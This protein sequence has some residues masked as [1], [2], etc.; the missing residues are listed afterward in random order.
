MYSCS[1]VCTQT[2]YQYRKGM[3]RGAWFW[4]QLNQ[5]QS[6]CWWKP[7]QELSW[8][9]GWTS[10]VTSSERRLWDKKEFTLCHRLLEPR[11]IFIN[12]KLSH[13]PV[14]LCW[15]LPIQASGNQGEKTCICREK[16][17]EGLCCLK[18]PFL[19]C[20]CLLFP[21]K[22]LYICGIT[23]CPIYKTSKLLQPFANSVELDGASGK[24]S[25]S[26]VSYQAWENGR[27]PHI[28]EKTDIFLR[29]PFVKSVIFL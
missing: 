20:S 4:C 13:S 10:A 12:C 1:M 22:F 14:L 5:H 28:C 29:N 11:H 21:F 8:Q 24:E 3:K 2:F 16:L 27:C 23:L 25:L 26:I 15:L 19:W 9:H 6:C 17:W 18:D 7:V